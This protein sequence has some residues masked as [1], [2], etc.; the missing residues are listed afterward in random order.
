M[1]NVKHRNKKNNK[2]SSS[3]IIRAQSPL[4]LASTCTS[5]KD[6]ELT[7]NKTAAVFELD[8]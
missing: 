8:E 3:I 2:D 1:D 7:L 6:Q 5:R 4:M